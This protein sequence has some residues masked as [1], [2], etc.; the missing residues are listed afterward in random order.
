MITSGKGS[1]GLVINGAARGQSWSSHVAAD[2]RETGLARQD[3]TAAAVNA[4]EPKRRAPDQKPPVNRA[5]RWPRHSTLDPTCKACG[6]TTWWLFPL[7]TS[8]HSREVG[9]Y[10]DRQGTFPPPTVTLTS[11]SVQYVLKKGSN[12]E[13]R[14]LIRSSWP[15]VYADWLFAE[16]LCY[17]DCV[18][19]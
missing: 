17:C 12:S 16:R 11:V 1:A 13:R 7:S 9:L 4:T 2:A 14:Y 19:C 3:L 10:I 18:C 8:D 6:C 5:S 15:L